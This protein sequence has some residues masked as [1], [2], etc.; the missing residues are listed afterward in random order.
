MPLDTLRYDV[1]ESGVATAEDAA[2]VAIA[3]YAV[4]LVGSAL[5][6]ALEPLALVRAM[7]S[8]GRNERA[9]RS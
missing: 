4:A 9:R 8:A 1:A 7:L 3:G 2:R 5:M 6:S